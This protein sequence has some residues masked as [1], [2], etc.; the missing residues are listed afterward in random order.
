MSDL[1]LVAIVTGG[2]ATINALIVKS[3]QKKLLVK[4]DEV[5]TLV[6]DRSEKQDKRIS[7]LQKEVVMLREFI[8]KDEA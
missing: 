7:D 8:A 1:V 2:F 5:H 6:N 4:T 3:G